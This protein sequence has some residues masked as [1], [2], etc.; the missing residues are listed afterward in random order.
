M[1]K[2]LGLIGGGMI[3]GALAR[4]AVAAGLDV[5][6][7]NSR[8]PETLADLVAELGDRAH[9]ATP[10]EAAR[11][12]DL[13]V[14]TIPLHVY[15]RLSA[16]DLAGR[17]VI[18]TMN[19]YPERDGR[20]AELDD[21]GLTSSALVQ[22]HLADSYVVKAF[23]TIDFRRLLTSARP[24]GAAD[25]SALPVA[26]DHAAA[27]DEVIRLLD[28]LGYDAVDL[29]PLAESWRAEPGTPVYVTPY[30]AERPAGLGQEEAGRWFFETPGVPV[31]AG[32]VRE[33]TDAAVRG[34]PG[35][36]RMALADD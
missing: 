16:A 20:L 24:A 21:G 15:T 36:A 26:G 29:G 31:P 10:A 23:N 9:A 3:G 27:K 18:D 28:T 25:R 34:E 7:S 17:T 30:L 22:R 1:T 11:A 32:R 35:T 13:V 2:T 12:G 5:V 8:G 19:Y 14:A 4:L 6:L 33:L